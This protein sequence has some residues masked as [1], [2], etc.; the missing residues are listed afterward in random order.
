MFSAFF[1]DRPKFALVISLVILLV[2]GIALSLIPV[3]EFPEITP[4]QVTVSASY[5][6]A[7]AEGVEQ[8][9]AV[10]IEEQVNG[11]EGMSYMSSTSSS[12]GTYKLN[13]T[14][15]VGTDAD[16]A[17]VNVQNR[18]AVANTQL[19]QEVIRQGL[20]TRKQ[21]PNMLLIVNLISP[22]SSRDSLFLSNYAS[23]YLQDS[24]AR[25]AGVGD[26]SQFGVQDYGMRVWLDPDRLTALGLT[27][28][29]VVKAIEE[30]NI[31]ASAGS[32]G[33]PPFTK[34]PQFQY[35]LQAKGRLATVE[36]FES[37][38]VR[39]R[40]DGSLVRLKDIARLELGSQSYNAISKLNSQPAASVV[41]YQS[42]GANALQVADQIYAELE[43]LAT[44]FPPDM[45]YHIL[46]DTTQAVRASVQEVINTLFVT[47][48]LV[49]AVTFL[50]L[51]DWRSTLIP[52]C[53]IPVS[54]VGTFAVMYVLGFSANTITLFA[55]ILAIGIVVD[56]SIV[57]VENVQRI[58]RESALEAREATR[59]AMAE[60]TGPVIA[61]TL[62]L[63]AV[64]VP[65][66]F[67]PGI[68]GRLY[69]QFAVTISVA[70]A[71]SSLNALTLSPA[72]CRL[73]LKPDSG[74]AYG[75][76]RAFA[77]LVNRSR[78]GYVRVCAL[79]LRYLW[80][81]LLLALIFLVA[82]V[83][84][85]LRAPSGFLPTEDKGVL[86]VN[87]QLPD[88]ASLARTETVIDEIT[89]MTRDTAGITDVISVTG[90]SILGGAASNAGLVIP[91]LAPWDERS[92]PQLQWEPILGQ[93]N[94]S[95]ASIATAEAFAFPPPPIT[96]LGTG[97]G[98]EA[99]LQD[100]GGGS[101]QKLAAAMGSLV[102]AANQHPAL[103]GVFS[104]YSA[105]APQL[106]LDI[107]RERAKVLG[108]SLAD[109]FTT[110]SANLSSLYVNDFNLFGKSYRVMVQAEAE[111]RNAIKDI[112]NLYV[113]SGSGEMV[114]L[115][116]L[117]DVEPVLGPLSIT[118]YNQFKSAA[119]TG[120][121]APGYSSGEAIAA[122]EQVAAEALP[123]G[124]RIEWTGTSK[125]ELAAGALV[126]YIFALAIIFAYLFLVAQ[127]ES[128]TL[129]LGVIS[130]VVFALFGALLPVVVL[131][132]LNNNLYAQIGI[133]MLIGLA[134]KS[135]ILIV[136]FAKERREQGLS[137]HEAALAAARLRFRAVLM[138]ALSF[139]LGVSPLLFA[140]GAGAASRTS[141]GF[142]VFGGMLAATVIGIFFIPVL[143][144]L[145]Q[146][147]RLSV[148][149]VWQRSTLSLAKLVPKETEQ[150]NDE[151]G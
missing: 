31:Q 24:L 86:M 6:G 33:A 95:L 105:S 141:V 83:Y 17:A 48:I 82:T 139:I 131:P 30:Q 108:V 45:E 64:F 94:A 136:E 66:S 26:V 58:M 140:S 133:V 129:P 71:I 120:N 52:V 8:S 41:V 117:I 46:Y 135:A 124:Y 67:M 53:A 77:W 100:L 7:N 144:V 103:M 15:E 70:V 138:T 76:L 54:L 87:V 19:P 75:L 115:R 107:D 151:Q 44:S 99:Q 74:Q 134:G 96:G 119:I 35:T 13:I 34:A 72:L 143:Y 132:F 1:I 61:T 89:Q 11:V 14:F 9:V 110:L 57:V 85:F 39:A 49:V 142:V 90:F 10:P 2:G 97:G 98:I 4:P 55:M 16:I 106:Y 127:Y 123:E 60:I 88:G 109:V 25:I 128:W 43:R 37:I 149:R 3:A 125:E 78:N 21:S 20:T 102:F 29:D 93:L 91:I 40:A 5:P 145:Y 27:A 51:A 56:D 32:L 114:P 73:L 18:V 147:I 111:Y 80:P 65:V 150:S 84:L 126:I 113:R 23:I 146:D 101:P 22:E 62:V 42:P 122:L 130:S 69:Q 50:F 118:R 28:S 81:A 63:L 112:G 137:T 104:T 47:F 121:P 116:A 148:P 68:T 59:R 38:I 92:S 12:D 36:E 79:M